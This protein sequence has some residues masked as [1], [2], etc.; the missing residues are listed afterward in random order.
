[1]SLLNLNSEHNTTIIEININSPNKITRNASVT[2]P[3]VN[4]IT[5]V[6]TTHTENINDV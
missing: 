1:M 2:K 4:I 6:T 3:D 5:L